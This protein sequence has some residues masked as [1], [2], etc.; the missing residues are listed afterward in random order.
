MQQINQTSSF[1]LFAESLAQDLRQAC[2]GLWR[3]RAFTAVALVTLAIGIGVNAAVFTVANTALFKGFPLVRDNERIL[4]LTTTKNAVSYPDYQDWQARARSFEHIALA[5]GVFTTFSG[6]GGAPATYFTTQVT[7]NAFTLLGVAPILGRDFAPADAQRGATPVVILR[8]DLWRSRFG[9]SPSI[10]GATVQLNGVPTVVIGVMPADFSFPEN[11]S[12][13]TPLVAT[14][15]ALNRKTFYARYAFARLAD[16]ASRNSAVAEMDVIGQQ[17]ATTYPATNSDR[18]PVVRDFREF[19]IGDSGTKTYQALWGAV[20]FVLLIACGNVANLL[21]NRSIRRSR[22]ISV[23]LALGAKRGRIIRS[24]VL[25]SVVLSGLAGIVGWWIGQLCVRVYVSAQVSG[26][27]AILSYTTDTQLLAYAIAISIGSGVLVSAPAAWW[28]TRSNINHSL[29]NTGRGVAGPGRAQRFA[30]LLIAAEI[31]LALIVLAGAASMA[32]SVYNVYAANVGINSTNVLTMSL[33]TPPE[34]YPE[35][36]QQISFYRRLM[37]GLDVVPGVRSVALASVA[38]TDRASRV[39]YEMPNAPVM[40]GT[41]P[42]VA[43]MT[44]SPG[45]FRTMEASVVSGREFTDLDGPS[46]ALVGI[47]NLAFVKRHSPQESMLGKSLRIFQDGNA[48]SLMIAGIVGDIVQDD[49]T[50]Q[51]AE[52][53]VYVPYQ[54]RPQPNMF[55]LARTGVEPATLA[56][57]FSAQVYALDPHLPVPA[58]MP[59]TDRFE[60]AYGFERNMT[61]VFLVFASVA[62][63]LAVVGLYAIVAHSVRT[64]TREIGIR[65]AIGAT[66]WQVRRLVLR[67]AAVPLIVGLTTGVAA[68]LALAFAIDPILVRV[69][70]A[71]PATLGAAAL[72]LTASAIAGCVVPTRYAL[73]IDPAIVLR[74]D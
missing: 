51:N 37:A 31:A 12:L 26:V 62:L 60:R 54:Q 23:R 32:R 15:E 61:A 18:S 29:N 48:Q 8:D 4:Y 42:T 27:A 6:D 69:S 41:Q 19:F 39:P 9:R 11:Q 72:A 43:L 67:Q 24:I 49:R 65:R 22:E 13:W 74:H 34:Q 25:E 16:G 68:S 40:E 33:Y 64:R 35:S 63:L 30:D 70:A 71:D 38:P 3:S 55:V 44:V 17:L 45:Y 28:M 47:V 58:V 50:R 73:R 10:I 2:R 21:L 53:V 7:A 56:Q 57:E 66:Q 36:V 14:D 20:S 52:P 59:L 46:S 1:S 5:R